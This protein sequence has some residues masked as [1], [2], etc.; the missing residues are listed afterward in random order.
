MEVTHLAGVGP[1][2]VACTD[3]AVVNLARVGLL[4]LLLGEDLHLCAVEGV[5]EVL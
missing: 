5:R 3:H 1:V 4:T 2:A